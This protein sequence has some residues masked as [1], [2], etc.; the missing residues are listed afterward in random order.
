MSSSNELEMHMRIAFCGLWDKA[1]IESIV[2]GKKNGKFILPC[3]QVSLDW[4][5][6]Y[7]KMGN[8]TS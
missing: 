8:T 6:N 5:V 3:K 7:F 1:E 4:L 2:M